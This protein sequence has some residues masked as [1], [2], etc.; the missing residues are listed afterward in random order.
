[1]DGVPGRFEYI[2]EEPG[3]LTHS[4]FVKGGTINGAPNTP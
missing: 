1:M 2:V 4:R 3:R